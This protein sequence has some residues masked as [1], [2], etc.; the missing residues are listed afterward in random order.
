MSLTVQLRLDFSSTGTWLPTWLFDLC[1]NP[2]ALKKSRSKIPKGWSEN[3]LW[4]KPPKEPPKAFRIWKARKKG[5]SGWKSS[6]MSHFKK[7][8]KLTIFWRFYEFLSNQNVNIARFAR[9]VE[10]DFFCN[11]QTLWKVLIFPLEYNTKASYRIY[12]KVCKN[13]LLSSRLVF[14][15]AKV[16]IFPRDLKRG[17]QY[18]YWMVFLF[19][20]SFFFWQKEMKIRS[21]QMWKP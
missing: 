13:V 20:F 3:T 11:F 4:L 6:K 5:H 15:A 9:N 21:F 12:V 14:L 10:W 8:P 17:V 1:C 2:S 18:Y 19:F 7:S 16:N